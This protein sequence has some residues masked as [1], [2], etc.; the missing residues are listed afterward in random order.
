LVF[1]QLHFFIGLSPKK[2]QN[3][4]CSPTGKSV[5]AARRWMADGMV[6]AALLIFVNRC[7]MMIKNK[8]KNNII[9]FCTDIRKKAVLL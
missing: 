2:I 5:V 4:T 7:K 3:N 6:F 9:M 8:H 1:S